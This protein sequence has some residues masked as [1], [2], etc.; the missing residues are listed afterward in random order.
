MAIDPQPYDGE[1]FGD[2]DREPT[3][4]EVVSAPAAAVLRELRQLRDEVKR[5]GEAVS[6]LA[7]AVARQT[8]VLAK[9]TDKLTDPIVRKG[10]DR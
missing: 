7:V 4:Q 1:D 9:L 10:R 3:H 5:Q 8:D 2:S 6:S